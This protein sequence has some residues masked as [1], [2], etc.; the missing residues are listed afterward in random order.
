MGQ[1]I[2]KIPA[3]S[4]LGNTETYISEDNPPFLIEHGTKD[5]L[6]PT[7]QS[8]NFAAKLTPVRPRKSNYS[9]FEK[10]KTWWASI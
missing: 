5:Q 7:Q 1:K 3:K 4:Q 9:P 10:R 2:T 8:V 6:V